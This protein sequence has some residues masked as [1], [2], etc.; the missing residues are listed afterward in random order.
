MQKTCFIATTTKYDETAPIAVLMRTAYQVMNVYLLTFFIIP[1]LSFEVIKY[2]NAHNFCLMVSRS[3]VS[4]KSLSGCVKALLHYVL[5][6]RV[7]FF[8][9]FIDKQSHQGFPWSSSDIHSI[10]KVSEYSHNVTILY[11]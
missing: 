6:L 1:T 9:F 2:E 8:V 11:N 5:G 10:E 3:I 4:V 7:L